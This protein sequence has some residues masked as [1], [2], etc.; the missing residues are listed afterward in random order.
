MRIF[1]SRESGRFDYFKISKLQF[2][3][4]LPE[5]TAILLGRIINTDDFLVAY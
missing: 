2:F 4:N 1:E 5:S 3:L